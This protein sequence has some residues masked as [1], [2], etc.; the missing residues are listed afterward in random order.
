MNGKLLKS[1][2][3]ESDT[4]LFLFPKVT[5]ALK[6]KARVEA[7]RVARDD[8]HG[9]GEDK[10]DP[11]CSEAVEMGRRICGK[12]QQDL[13]PGWMWGPKERKE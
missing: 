9:P 4:V 6:G 7:G 12:S 13:L 10:G 3:Q 8:C 2:K 11:G 5:A 1:L